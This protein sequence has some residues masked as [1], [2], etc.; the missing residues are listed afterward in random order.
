M[1]YHKDYVWRW[2]QWHVANIALG[3]LE[4]MMNNYALVAKWILEYLALH[5][6][7]LADVKASTKCRWCC[8]EHL[9]TVKTASKFEIAKKNWQFHRDYLWDAI[10]HKYFN[11]AFKLFKHQSSTHTLATDEWMISWPGEDSSVEVRSTECSFHFV[12]E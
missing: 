10:L 6:C 11:N 7:I 3:L 8:K 2:C 5:K 1:H 4:K 9:Y 12:F